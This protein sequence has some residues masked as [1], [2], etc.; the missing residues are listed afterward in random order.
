MKNL[1]RFVM[2]IVVCFVLFI[3]TSRIL[4]RPSRNPDF[5]NRDIEGIWQGVLKVQ[6]V[7]LRIVFKISRKSDGTLTATMDSPD[8]GAK[9]IPVEDVSFK[10][11]NLRMEVKSIRGIF[12]GKLKKDFLTI[13]GEWKQS[14]L[15]L[16]LV[17]KHM[18]KTPEI[19][20]PQEPKKPYPYKEEEVVYENKEAGVKLAG[21]LTLPRGRG[22]FPA[23]LLITGSGAEDRNETVFGH[24]PF[25]VLADYLTRHGISV[26]RVDDRGVGGSTGSTSQSTSKDFAS[27]VLAGVKYLKSR[28]E[29]NPKQIGLIGH[30][31]GGIIAPMAATQSSDIAFI[32]LMAGPGIPGDSLLLLQSTAISKVSGM[33]DREIERNNNLQ[34]QIYDIVKNEKNNKIAE[35]RLRKI[36]KRAVDR[37]SEKERASMSE[38][39]VEK[40][41]NAQ[42]KRLLTPWFRFFLTYNPAPTLTKVKCPVLAINGEK[43]LQVPPEENLNAIKEALKKGGNKHFTVKELPGLNHLFQTANTGLPSEY[44]RIEETISPFALKFITNWILKQTQKGKR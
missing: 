8:Q 42:I 40:N 27:D 32:V 35:K 22:P 1:I 16:P 2:N 36:M 29:I 34:R 6:G 23:V 13:E 33:D 7:K 11:G 12:E 15:T 43:D 26:L 9:D 44:A 41:I 25:L 30:S 5:S 21:T 20:R 3:P 37:M 28:K 19:R 17:L 10:N 39:D 4:A 38:E 31:E 14:G 18:E 24:R